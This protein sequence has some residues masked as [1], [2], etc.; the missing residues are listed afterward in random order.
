VLR[1]VVTSNSA[2]STTSSVNTGSPPRLV[3]IKE[4]AHQEDSVGPL[5][6]GRPGVYSLGPTERLWRYLDLWAQSRLLGG[7]YIWR[8]ERE[9]WKGKSPW[10]WE[11]GEITTGPGKLLMDGVPNEFGY[12]RPPNH[13]ICVHKFGYLRRI[14]RVSVRKF[15]DLRLIRGQSREGFLGIGGA[16]GTGND[17]VKAPEGPSGPNLW[18]LQEF[19]YLASKFARHH[20]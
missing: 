19:Y 8:G 5:Q 20:L 2:A 6:C 9:S 4:C 15:G 12:L 18:I 13:Q 17:H 1:I 7:C 14:W 3:V 10:K 11:L 16:V